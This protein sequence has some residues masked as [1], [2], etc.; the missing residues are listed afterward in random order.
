MKRIATLTAGILALASSANLLIA[1]TNRPVPPSPPSVFTD[2]QIIET[3]G[4]IIAREKNLA[5]IEI[6][7]AELAAFSHG[8]SA[9]VH[10]RP[11]PCN[12]QKSYQDLQTL[13]R[14]RREK[15]VRALEQKN[16][17]AAKAFFGKLR[18]NP[19]CVELA[20]NVIC[21]IVKPGNGAAPKPQQTVNV[22]YTG[23]LMDG[24]EFIQMGPLDMILVT[25]H[26][27]CRG[28]WRPCKK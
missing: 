7:P 4:W 9:N 12:L 5:G 15:A 23:R 24:T 25:N 14:T 28:G 22:H 11:A 16:E 2:R 17:A 10:G 1:Q 6:S 20:G 13:A 21:E 26:G 3:W 18:N 27:I 8:F 19:N